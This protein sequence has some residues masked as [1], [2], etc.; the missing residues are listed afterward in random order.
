MDPQKPDRKPPQEPPFRWTRDGV[1]AFAVAGSIIATWL[2]FG[3]A[4]SSWVDLVWMLV[5]SFLVLVLVFGAAAWAFNR[6][7]AWGA[8]R[9]EEDERGS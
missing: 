1:L 2:W 8:R 6:V 7:F 4:G 9:A 5:V 3:Q